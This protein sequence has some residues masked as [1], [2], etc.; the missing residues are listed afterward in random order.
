MIAAL[1]FLTIFGRGRAPNERTLGWF[2]ATG[3]IIGATLGLVWWLADKAFTSTLL[4]GAIV[5]FADLVITG[6]IHVD[7]LA[8]SIDGLL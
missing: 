2:P 4:I 8:D 5:I 7:G 6:M 3:A 1:S